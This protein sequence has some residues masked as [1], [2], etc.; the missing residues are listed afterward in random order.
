[1][2]IVDGSWH[3]DLSSESVE[4]MPAL[5]DLVI[6]LPSGEIQSQLQAKAQEHSETLCKAG[7]MQFSPKH[8]EHKEL[9]L[10]TDDRLL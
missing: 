10:P 3:K 6:E 4:A 7:S 1:M 9:L 5:Q 8:F 2:D